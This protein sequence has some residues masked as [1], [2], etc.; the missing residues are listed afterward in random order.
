MIDNGCGMLVDIY[1]IEKIFG[2]E[3]ILIKLYVGG[4][5]LNKNYIFLGGL[6]GVGILVVNVFL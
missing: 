1:L 4:K 6:Y 2:V 5:F 3:L